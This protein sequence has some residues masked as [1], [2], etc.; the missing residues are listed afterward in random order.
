MGVCT[1]VRGMKTGQK[2]LFFKDSS[3]ETLGR[4]FFSVRKALKSLTARGYGFVT[5]NPT[6]ESILP[7]VMN[8]GCPVSRIYGSQRMGSYDFWNTERIRKNALCN[9][10][11]G[12]CNACHKA[13]VLGSRKLAPSLIDEFQSEVGDL[14]WRDNQNAGEQEQDYRTQVGSYGHVPEDDDSGEPSIIN[15]LGTDKLD[16]FELERRML[17]QEAVQQEAAR[18]REERVR[19]SYIPLAVFISRKEMGEILSPDE[20]KVL[21]EG[22]QQVRN[23]ANQATAFHQ[24]GWFTSLRYPE[25][26]KT[27]RCNLCAKWRQ[28]GDR[29]W[30]SRRT[31]DVSVMNANI[32]I[33]NPEKVV[34]DAKMVLQGCRNIYRSHFLD[35]LVHEFKYQ[36]SSGI[37]P[38]DIAPKPFMWE[39]HM[40]RLKDPLVD[41]DSVGWFDTVAGIEELVT[42]IFNSVSKTEKK[43]AVAQLTG[44]L[45]GFRAAKGLKNPPIKSDQKMVADWLD[46]QLQS[47]R[48][49]YSDKFWCPPKWKTPAVCMGCWLQRKGVC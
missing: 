39:D 2:T 14:D 12:A 1:L 9:K 42:N 24:C 18:K 8:G 3:R 38:W 26:H 45:Q 36:V 47:F 23:E 20:E 21:A 11:D 35:H 44:F 28:S 16:F 15:V 22:L 43:D 31:Q 41:L 30:S 49:P 25:I 33:R 29:V 13:A 27:H 32:L 4:D 19:A 17:Q 34:S 40:D 46:G 5:I 37:M 6:E 48:L 7:Q 10:C